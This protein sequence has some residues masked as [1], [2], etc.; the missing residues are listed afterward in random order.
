MTGRIKAHQEAEINRSYLDVKAMGPGLTS[1]HSAMVHQEAKS[2]PKCQGHGCRPAC[3][4]PE[5]LVT[6]VIGE[7]PVN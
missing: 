1:E 5:T 6:G 3:T 7:T 2:V 4:P